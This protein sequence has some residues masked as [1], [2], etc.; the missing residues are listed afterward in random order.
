MKKYIAFD[1]G[2]TNVKH[3]LLDEQGAIL[4][5][6]KYPTQREHL[7]KFLIDMVAVIRSYQESN[8]DVEGIAISLPGAINTETGFAYFGGAITALDRQ[9]ITQLLAVHTSLPI[10]VEND[11]NCVA[12]AEKFNG[13]ATECSN[14]ICFTIGTGIGGG[15]YVNNQIVHGHNFR[16]GEFGFMV[17]RGSEED[18][19]SMHDNAAT[20]SLIKI[21][22][23][24]K[25]IPE[26]ERVEGIVIFEEAETNEQV[27]EIVET[28][29]QSI[30]FGIYNLAVALNPEKILIGGAVSS[31]DDLLE[32]INKY[33]VKLPQWHLL[34][35]PLETCKH[36]NDAGL[37]GAFNNFLTKSNK[38]SQ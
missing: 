17:T 9:N 23:A 7:D 8:D 20:G 4:T 25:G 6:D 27:K 26:S 28:W 33:L 11:G 19:Q 12:L 30:S 3:G 1:V 32:G 5:K 16:G 37:L 34:K 13:N 14:F 24:F 36:H 31:R 29:L 10:E 2:G 35:V 18:R 15:I 38:I 21:Y 22:K